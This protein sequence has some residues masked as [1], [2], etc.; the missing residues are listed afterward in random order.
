[1]TAASSSPSLNQ[2]CRQ[3]NTSKML[4]HKLTLW[5]TFE[6]M[7]ILSSEKIVSRCRGAQQL[8]QDVDQRDFRGHNRRY[9]RLWLDL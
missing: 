3:V 5:R 1:M 6:L 8:Q 7:D 2:A 9:A 4:S